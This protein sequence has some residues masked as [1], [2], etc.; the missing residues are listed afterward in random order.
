M[1]KLHK[2]DEI[3]F[4]VITEKSTIQNSLNKYQF[5]VHNQTSKVSIKV[6]IEKLFEVKV[7]SINM[8]NMKGK[9]K[10]KGGKLAK[11]QDTKK[12]IITLLDGHKISF[13]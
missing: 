6:A 12:A 5:I 9:V 13:E 11:M 7:K 3:L 4:P 8:L 2:C 10:I 1:L